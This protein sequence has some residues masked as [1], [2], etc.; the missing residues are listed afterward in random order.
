[1][2]NPYDGHVDPYSLTQAIAAGARKYGAKLHQRTEVTGLTMRDDAT[3]DVHTKHG[4]IRAKRVVN[5]SGESIA[6]V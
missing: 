1:M 6:F 2:C 5:C 4:A 3:W